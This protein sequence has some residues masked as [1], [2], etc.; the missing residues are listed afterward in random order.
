MVG[1]PKIGGA[2]KNLLLKKIKDHQ[3]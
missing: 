1:K 3:K 2:A